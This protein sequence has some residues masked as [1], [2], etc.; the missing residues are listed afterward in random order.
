MPIN[1]PQLEEG[2]IYKR[3]EVE[4]YIGTQT[5]TSDFDVMAL[6]FPRNL[7]TWEHDGRGWRDG[8]EIVLQYRVFPMAEL[9]PQIWLFEESFRQQENHR[10]R[11]ERIV[12][13]LLGGNP[14][15]PVFMQENDPQRRIIEG[16]HRSVAL[17]QIES[18]CIPAFLAGYLNWFAPDGT[19][20]GF[21]QEDEIVSCTLREA[22]AFFMH[23]TCVD[24]KG[25]ELALFGGDRL[26]LCDEALVAKY[27][28]NVVGV[29][30]MTV[31]KSRPTLS[32][33]YVLRQFRHKGV[34]Y[35]L[36]ERAMLRFKE[37]GAQ[38]VFCDVQSAGMRATLDRLGQDQPGLSALV[39]MHIGFQP[40]EDLEMEFDDE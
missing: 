10:Q 14:V 1:M 32:T 31:S 11:V 27:R 34:A 13:V 38:R 7:D 4:S 40:G 24:Q 33:I 37:A 15:Y 9:K 5:G 23:A 30:T 28:G 6:H 26:R 22:Y 16:M 36:C 19:I 39:D 17:M 12:E 2:R 20:D 8:E 21:E 35:R 3:S 18:H 29:A 25:M